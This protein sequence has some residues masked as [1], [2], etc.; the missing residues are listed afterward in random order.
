M[1]EFC[2]IVDKKDQLPYGLFSIVCFVYVGA[3][4]VILLGPVLYILSPQHRLDM[5]SFKH[6]NR[7]ARSALQ[8]PSVLAWYMVY[9]RQHGIVVAWYWMGQ[10]F[11]R[12][13]GSLITVCIAHGSF[14]ETFFTQ[15]KLMLWDQDGNNPQSIEIGGDSSLT[16]QVGAIWSRRGQRRPPGLWVTKIC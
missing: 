12:P 13:S 16:D 4:V 6:P 9:W 1:N 14:R 3:F 8:I 10:G 15:H 2:C 5:G 7:T 11:T